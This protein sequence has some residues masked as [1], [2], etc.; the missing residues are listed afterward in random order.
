LKRIPPV[1][2]SYPP[3]TVVQPHLLWPH[4]PVP[5]TFLPPG[6]PSY[7]LQFSIHSS[8][9]SVL[10]SLFAFFCRFTS[11]KKYWPQHSTEPL[12][13]NVFPSEPWYDLSTLR[14]FFPSFPSA[15]F[16]LA[17]RLFPCP[18]RVFVPDPTSQRYSN[19]PRHYFVFPFFSRRRREVALRHSTPVLFQ[20]PFF[21][22]AGFLRVHG[23]IGASIILS[24]PRHG[25][26]V[27]FLVFPDFFFLVFRSFIFS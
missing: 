15:V 14:A 2:P 26:R 5:T 22:S 6:F 4:Y 1:T 25:L 16:L 8:P 18:S 11:T 12:G 3:L 23:C 10:F 19:H 17:G 9:V 13:R 20:G 21:S 24:T 27:C 7:F